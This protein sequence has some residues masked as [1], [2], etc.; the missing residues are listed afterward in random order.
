M[1]FLFALAADVI[2][3]PGMTYEIAVLAHIG[4]GWFLF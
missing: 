3:A 2:W 4:A 1:L